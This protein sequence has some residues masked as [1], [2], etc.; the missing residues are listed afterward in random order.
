MQKMINLPHLAN[1]V[2]G[3]PLYATRDLMDA[4]KSVLIPRIMGGVY[5]NP[6]MSVGNEK[7][8]GITQKQDNAAIA[9]IPVH[10]IMVPRRGQITA[11]CQ[12]LTSYE[13]LRSQ[14]Q[15]AVDDP[16]VM[17]IVLDINSSGGMVSGCKEVADFIFASRE[18]KPVTAIVNFN[19]FSAAYFIASACSRVVISNT[20]GVGSIGVIMEHLDASGW[21]E[22]NGLKFTSIFR[23]DNKNMFTPHEPLSESDRTAVQ[24][25]VD[26]SYETFV[27]SVAQYRGMDVQAVIN[28]QAALYYGAD[29]ITAGLADEMC[30]P[31]DA[32]NA[33]AGKYTPAAAAGKSS[34]Q[35]RAA[36]MNQQ[37]RM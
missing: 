24:A 32:I 37:S 34:I 28:T 31:Q 26:A 33:I 19:A 16:S 36:A 12:E 13:R 29:A 11:A 22:N 15:A 7:G 30:S 18:I 17:E 10:G 5:D 21:E 35:L 20:S 9:V 27:S 1:Q 23:G 25:M 2:F 6:E 4:V 8:E 14:V 3:A